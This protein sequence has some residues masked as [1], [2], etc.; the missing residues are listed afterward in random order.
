MPLGHSEQAFTATLHPTGQGSRE[1]VPSANTAA[2]CLYMQSNLQHFSYAL[3]CSSSPTV[4]LHAGCRNGLRTF[5][6]LS[7]LKREPQSLKL[8]KQSLTLKRLS[9]THPSSSVQLMLFPFN[10]DA[11]ELNRLPGDST[12]IFGSDKC[13]SQ[14]QLSSCSSL[15]EC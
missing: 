13:P 10:I 12:D 4:F 15:L 2:L 3:P 9:E 6:I 11:A 5:D 7:C 8:I 1:L 14:T